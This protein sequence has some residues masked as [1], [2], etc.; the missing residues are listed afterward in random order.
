MS[1]SLLASALLALATGWAKSEALRTDSSR[2]LIPVEASR[3]ETIR[4]K[5]DSRAATVP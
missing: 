1:R 2:A 3:L 5:K 4:R